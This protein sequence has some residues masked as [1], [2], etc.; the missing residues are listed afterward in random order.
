MFKPSNDFIKDVDFTHKRWSIAR[1]ESR[2]YLHVKKFR[3][4]DDLERGYIFSKFEKDKFGNPIFFGDNI[5]VELNQYYSATFFTKYSDL[6]LIVDGA[7]TIDRKPKDTNIPI[8]MD[9]QIA[10]FFKNPT[11]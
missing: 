4:P 10:Y 9:K 2:P 6:Y 5:V 8:N 3:L 11:L 7:L 1:L